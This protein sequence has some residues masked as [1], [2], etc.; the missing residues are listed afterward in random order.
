MREAVCAK[1][2]WDEKPPSRHDRRNRQIDLCRLNKSADTHR[3]KYMS[4]D[5]GDIWIDNELRNVAV[6]A[7]LLAKLQ[8]ISSLDDAELD[9]ALCDVPVSTGL[10]ARLRSIGT[11]G[12]VDLDD[13]LRDVAPRAVWPSDC[14]AFRPRRGKS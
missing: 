8:A 12:D 3:G 4:T 5:S 2:C 11:L 1:L 9:R 13:E 10:M 6:P 14:V 7:D